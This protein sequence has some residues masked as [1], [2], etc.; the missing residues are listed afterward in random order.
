MQYVKISEKLFELLRKHDTHP[1]VDHLFRNTTTIYS[2]GCFPIDYLDI[3]SDDKSKISYITEER[4]Y[5]SPERKLDPTY[6]Y[7]TKPGKL[8][9]KLYPEKEF[10]QKDLE[11]FAAIFKKEKGKDS[12][13]EICY[14]KG[15]EIRTW[16]NEK[17]YYNVDGE[18]GPLWSSC[19][20]HDYCESY[21]DIY[22]LNTEQVSLLICT[23]ENRLV[24][25]CILWHKDEKIYADRIYHYDDESQNAIIGHLDKNKI[26]QIYNTYELKY[27]ELEYGDES[28]DEF[29]YMDTMKVLN[30]KTLYSNEDMSGIKLDETDGGYSRSNTVW[31]DRQDCYIDEDNAVYSEYHGD[32]IEEC[33]ATFCECVNSYLHDNDVTELETGGYAPDNAVVTHHSGGYLYED[34]DDNVYLEYRDEYAN[35]QIDD[36]EYIDGEYYLTEDCLELHNGDMC[37]EENVIELH[38][39]RYTSEEL[40]DYTEIDGEYYLT[41]EVELV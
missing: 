33:Y 38:D 20:R 41:E 29:P 12:D 2:D 32:Y 14:V 8:I 28:I 24:G 23:K 37:Y 30:G 25:R 16:Y 39:G 1:V 36:V 4:Y 13:L 5:R 3:S 31:S 9:K 7:H 11:S 34:D 21:F 17:S 6:R 26:L 27:I 35:T 22:T 10:K 19:M 18:R 15:E 40:D